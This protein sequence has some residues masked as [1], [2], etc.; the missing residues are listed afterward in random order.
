MITTRRRLTRWAVAAAGALTLGLFGL[1]APA[2]AA[3]NIDPEEKGSLTIHKFEEPSSGGSPHD[4]TELDNVDGLT[5]LNDV[6]FTIQ[7]V[8]VDL[9]TNA[10]WE[11][12]EDR[13]GQPVDPASLPLVG[14][15]HTGVT[16]DGGSAGVTSFDSLALG[17]YLVQETGW[18]DSNPIV[19]AAEP[20]LVT[21]PIPNGDNTWN[22]DVHVYPKNS[23]TKVDKEVDDDAAFVLGDTVTWTIDVLIPYLP[24]GESFEGFEIQDPLEDRLAYES[25]TVAVVDGDGADV[26]LDSGDYQLTHSDGDVTL[27]FT[28]TGRAK[29]DGAQGG[30]V[31]LTILTTVVSIDAPGDDDHR[32]DYEDGVIVNDAMARIN[33]HDY[34][35]DDAFTYW[36]AL[37]IV[38]YA[39]DGDDRVSFLEGAEF[40]IFA[41]EADAEG[42]NN[43]LTVGGQPT[44]TTNDDGEILV[45]GLKEG[46]YWIVETKA[47]LGYT[48]VTDPIEVEV[49]R[50]AVAE[51]EVVRVLNHQK[52]PF[53]LPL[54]GAAGTVLFSM[55]GLG[56]I[57]VAT[58]AALR[59]RSRA[60]RA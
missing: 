11:W 15:V 2:A 21:V 24:Q 59:Y 37:E 6:T 1:T 53:E 29:L 54:T 47:P 46:T 4:G 49:T 10:G 52:P 39:E 43:P 60:T 58:G 38:K 32:D 36:G 40:Q 17:V 51:A 35:T 23:V 41:S 14:D 28:E 18:A 3:P 48:G 31:T 44:L 30:T 27:A 12:V 8:D 34:W 57:A 33:G 56:L 25:A 7:R 55:A 9:S 19:R 20:F 5:P 26:A 50:G 45:E 22:Y 16:G 13:I 42:G